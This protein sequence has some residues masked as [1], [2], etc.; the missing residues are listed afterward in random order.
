MH[1]YAN[2]SIDTPLENQQLAASQTL[3]DAQTILNY[4]TVL[5]QESAWNALG[6]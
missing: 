2:Q 4:N 5:G 6:P 1:Q 3:L